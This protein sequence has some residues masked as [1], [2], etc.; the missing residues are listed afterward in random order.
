MDPFSDEP[1]PD[2]VVHAT[3][4]DWIIDLKDDREF[5]ELVRD[6]YDRLDWDTQLTQAT[7]DGGYDIRLEKMGLSKLV[8]V[9]HSPNIGPSVVR[10]ISGTAL[11]ENV[12]GVSVVA[13]SFTPGAKEAAT[14][15]GKNSHLNVELKDSNRLHR[16][17][18][19]T[20]M[21]DLIDEYAVEREPIDDGVF[22]W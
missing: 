6:I 7:R 22:G 19:R 9:K 12:T 10:E 21:W 4:R 18:K 20:Q 17:F 13:I 15:I 16:L 3:F 2:S 11:A 8:E 14:K 5:E 1:H